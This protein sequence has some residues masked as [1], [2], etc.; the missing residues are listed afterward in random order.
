M[1]ELKPFM[2]GDH[3]NVVLTGGKVMLEPRAALALGMAVHELTTNYPSSYCDPFC[4]IRG[5]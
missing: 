3:S 1:E 5:F 4:W 2:A